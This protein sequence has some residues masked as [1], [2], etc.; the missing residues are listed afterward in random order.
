MAAEVNL[1]LDAGNTFTTEFVIGDDSGAPI[2][3][4]NYTIQSQIRKSYIAPS[5]F[6]FNITK[7]DPINGVVQL[8]LTPNQTTAL[9]NGRFLYDAQYVNGSQSVKFIKGILTVYPSVTRPDTVLP[10]G[11]TVTKTIDIVF[12]QSAFSKTFTITDIQVNGNS[13]VTA[14]G[15]GQAG[16]NSDEAE[17]DGLLL[18]AVPFDGG[19]IL[20]ADAIP[21][22]VVGTFTIQYQIFTK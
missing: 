10:S 20:Y 5:S 9:K 17:L 18:R 6:A 11:S 8:S 19:F 3:I 14:F 7:T 21:G 12:D 2:D 13:V 1:Y 15:V 16:L 4:T 22:P